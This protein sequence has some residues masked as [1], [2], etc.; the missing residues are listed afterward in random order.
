MGGRHR[1]TGRQSHLGQAERDYRRVSPRHPRFG[2]LAIYSEA[3]AI[4]RWPST[5][6]RA[7][8]LT[9]AASAT[10]F[11]TKGATLRLKTDGTI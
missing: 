4:D 10:A 5:I 7:T 1:D 2:Q 3:F 8:P 9:R 6:L 11:A